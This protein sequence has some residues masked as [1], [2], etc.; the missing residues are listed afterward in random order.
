MKKRIC[1]GIGVSLLSCFLGALPVK[2]G[3]IGFE[4]V[5]PLPVGVSPRGIAVGNVLGNGTQEVVVANFGSPTFIGQSTPASLLNPSNSTLSVF[6]P[7]PQGLQ[8]SATVPTAPSPRGLSL[9]DF[10]NQKRQ[11]I[12]VTAYD[13]NL[14]QVFNWIGGQWV[15]ADE[16]PTLA[17][18]VGVATGFVRPGDPPFVAVADYGSNTLSLFSL[19]GGRLGPRFD[20]PV[21]GGPTQ[22]AIG[23]L[24][25]GGTNQIAVVCLAS[26][27]IDLL[28]AV[29][30]GPEESLSSVTV[31]Q[32]LNL[33]VGSSPAD[34]RIADL[35]NDGRPDLVVAD[36]SGNA[37]YI[38][39]Q[40]KDGTLLAQPALTTSGNHP[41][42]LTV[43]D[44]DGSGNKAIIVA[45]RDSDSLDIFQPVGGQYQLTQ[46]LKT[47]G[48][49]SSSFG[50]IE[51]GVIDTREAGRKDLVATHM[52]SNT[53]QV[54]TQDAPLA[55]V[56]T[57][58]AGAGSPGNG[59]SSF[60]DETTFCY[61]NPCH[62]GPVK[63]SFNLAAPSK[64]F[65]E[66]FDLSGELVWNQA[67][68]AGQ[69]QNGLNTLSWAATNQG[70]QSLATGLYVYRI[71]VGD[72][73]VTKKLALFH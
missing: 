26:H 56:S 71:S 68:D 49:S 5:Q 53:L 46:T 42:G 3:T 8:L 72:Q 33:P 70:G 1:L 61:P 63:F 25:G 57:P 20:V 13:A 18:P 28:S 69:T 7:S 60:T 62:G 54:L 37:V 2:A 19:K 35:N 11:S 65:L 48:G 27:K 12:F 16:A 47:S 39:L 66:V 36:F 50:P 73:S 22:V 24:N 44:L 51:V 23:D 17:M 43:A 15:K 45:N 31:T 40:Q 38:Y 52:N 9:F 58:T 14:L 55:A 67:V 34:L 64:V 30:G 10:G 59:R 21:D 29:S 4:P 32:A 6:S 41:N